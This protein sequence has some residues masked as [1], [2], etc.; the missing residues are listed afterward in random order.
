MRIANFTFKIAYAL[1]I[2]FVIYCHTTNLEEWN[3][4]A[5]SEFY[6]KNNIYTSWV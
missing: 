5:E 6:K 3:L 1:Q 2:T 4:D